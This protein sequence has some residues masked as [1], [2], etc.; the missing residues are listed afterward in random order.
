MEK[1]KIKLIIN[2]TSGKGKAKKSTPK[3]IQLLT[4]GGYDVTLFETKGRGDATNFAK[5]CEDENMVVCVGGDGTLHEVVNGMM[6]RETQVPLGY[7]PMGSVNDFARSAGISKN[8]KKSISTIVNGKS[9]PIDVCQFSNEYFIYVSAA[10][11]FAKTSCSTS[12]KLKNKLGK[13]A[14]LLL[15]IKEFFE[16][17]KMHLKIVAD[18][19]EYEDDYLLVTIGNTKSIGGLLKFKGNFVQLDDG[20][21]ELLLIKY[22]KNVFQLARAVRKYNSHCWNSEILRFLHV[23]NVQVYDRNNVLWSLD[24]EKYNGSSEDNIYNIEIKHRA[25]QIRVDADKW[26]QRTGG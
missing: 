22:P 15:G 1:Q 13:L 7:I 10:G 11:I 8:I 23:K 26:R 21:A 2:P 3:I 18:G 24:G 5:T 20:Y 9:Y 16:Y 17:K 14:Y 19:Q 12:Q 6:Q 25:I 4:E